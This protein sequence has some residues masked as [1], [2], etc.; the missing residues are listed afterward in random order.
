MEDE[1]PCAVPRI[2]PPVSPF[3]KRESGSFY[4]GRCRSWFRQI[5]AVEPFTLLRIN[6]VKYFQLRFTIFALYWALSGRVLTDI[7]RPVWCS[8]KLWGFQIQP[9]YDPGGQNMTERFSYLAQTVM[10]LY[11]GLFVGCQGDFVTIFRA[12]SGQQS[13]FS[14]PLSPNSLP[15]IHFVKY[16]R[17]GYSRW[18]E[19]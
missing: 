4:R 18:R 13:A 6:S 5:F 2:N 7:Y 8:Q 16:F 10:I 14:K 17:C 11:D 12:F 15:Y 19:C 1:I 3:L 9:I